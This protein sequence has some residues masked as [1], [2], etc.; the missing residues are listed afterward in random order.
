MM[1]PELSEGIQLDGD[2]HL[3]SLSGVKSI[4]HFCGSY[5][6][7]Y[8]VVQHKAPAPHGYALFYK[9]LR[10]LNYLYLEYKFIFL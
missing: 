6:Q 8:D 7:V 10:V 4:G 9:L 5:R 2:W 1:R 3:L